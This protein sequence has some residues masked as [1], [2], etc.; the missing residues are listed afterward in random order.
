MFQSQLPTL[1]RKEI[2]EK[3]A[4]LDVARSILKVEFI[5]LDNI[6]DEVLDLMLPWWLFPETQMRPTIVNLWGMTGTGKT[7]LI[8]RL[9][10]ILSYR[11]RTLV[12]D[13]GQYGESSSALKYSFTGNLEFFN[14]KAP[15]IMFDEFQF[16]KTID[17]GKEVNND[18]LRVIWDLLDSGQFFYESYMSK[19]THGRATKILKLLLNCKERGVEVKNGIITKSQK[20]FDDIMKSNTINN[21]YDNTDESAPKPK[22][23]EYFLQNHFYAGVYSL[24]DEHYLDAEDVL[25]VIK[26]MDLDQIIDFLVAALAEE[27]S[28]K[29][30]NLSKSLIFVVGNLDE[31]YYMSGVI[32]PD[33]SPDDFYKS[34]LKINIANIKRALQER[35]RNEQIARLGNN[36]VIYP[37]FNTDSYKKIIIKHLNITKN[38]ILERFGLEI[39]FDDS[40]IEIVFQEG[41][42]PTQGARPVLTTV[43]NL[44][45]G[46]ISKMIVTILENELKVAKLNWRFENDFYYVQFLDKKGKI[47][48]SEQYPINLKVNSL[49]KS[50]DNDMQA[51]VAVHESGHC[52]LAALA[53]QLLPEY[54]VTRTVSSD[55]HGFC[56]LNLPEGIDTKY[57]I[58]KQIIVA[59]GGYLAEKMIF[60]EEYTSTGVSEDIRKASELAHSAVKEFGM[61]MDPLRYFI[62][63]GGDAP[64]FQYKEEHEQ[65]AYQLVRECQEEG[66]AILYRNRTLLLE[67]ANYLTSH[68]R[69]EKDLIQQ[70]IV[71]FSTEDWVTA[72]GFRDAEHYYD[73]KAQVQGMLEKT[74]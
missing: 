36:H 33:I 4:Q 46:Y 74:K 54:V 18:S 55:S 52:I 41:V 45:E 21:V 28:Q 56:K 64:F 62:P 20:V 13:M 73:F 63:T 65:L 23:E 51:Y 37:A 10:E 70:Y 42:F 19:W 57:F 38:N 47:I 27:Q 2:L 69:M 11:D 17:D 26:K 34:T 40:I 39:A 29:L 25:E 68:S 9:A 12:F 6:I 1:S 14:N 72:T 16:A 30:M 50:Q 32:N 53:L 15:I 61:G 49:R 66:A 58:K 5:G 24:V 31:A 59:L 44:I 7:A 22:K 3:K 8:K 60:G 71:K 35:F 67:L 43:R 48:R